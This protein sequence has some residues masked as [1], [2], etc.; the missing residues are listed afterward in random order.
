MKRLRLVITKKIDESLR[1]DAEERGIEVIEKEF[2][3]IELLPVDEVRELAMQNI[4]A[5]FTSKNAVKALRASI[6]DGTTIKWK[7]FCLAGATQAIVNKSFPLSAIAATAWNAAELAEKIISLNVQEE[8]VFFCG[9]KRRNDLP[10]ALKTGSIRLREIV[11]YTTLLTPVKIEE[12]IDAVGF[13][14]PT[15]V[16]SFFSV[17]KVN[18][19]T[20]CFSVGSTTSRTLEKYAVKKILT[21]PEASEKSLVEE[22]VKIMSKH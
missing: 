2:I 13:F 12:P 20:L 9:D 7:I 10:D 18:D 1:K 5:I 8:L 14:S 15:A 22:A 11:S 4:T 21:L 19:D 6:A 16:E 17:N 3:R